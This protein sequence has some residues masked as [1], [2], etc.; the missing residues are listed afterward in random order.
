MQN[1]ILDA[2]GLIAY[3]NKEVGENIV[4]NKIIEASNGNIKLF[5]H[6]A[7]VAEAYYDALKRG[8]LTKSEMFF[9]H[10]S[11]LPISIIT[12]TSNRLIEEMGFFKLQYKTSFADLFVLA[13]AKLQDAIIITSDHHEFD[14]VEKSGNLKFEWIR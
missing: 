1:Y 3:Y 10:L 11:N 6:Q 2:C 14:A 5:I 8:F 7:S 12:E 9:S 13:T 4:K